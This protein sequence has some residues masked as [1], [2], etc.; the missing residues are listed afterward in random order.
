MSNIG[1]DYWSLSKIAL[2]FVILLYFYTD[3]TVKNLA[4][5]LNFSK[6][7]KNSNNSGVTIFNGSNYK[8]SFS[9]YLISQII[10]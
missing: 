2:T 10:K 4:L 1:R 7:S 6:E 8:R 3:Y 5:F 9:V